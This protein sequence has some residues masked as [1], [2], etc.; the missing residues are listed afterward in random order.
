MKKI[1]ICLKVFFLTAFFLISN[2][3]FCQIRDTNYIDCNGWKQGVWKEV[4]WGRQYI[5]GRFL[6]NNK[7]GEWRVFDDNR[8]AWSEFYSEGWWF[9]QKEQIG[10]S[11]RV[12]KILNQSKDTLIEY[13]Y[14]YRNN[15]QIE[16]QIWYTGLD[17]TNYQLNR[18]VSREY[19]NRLMKVKSITINYRPFSQLKWGD[20]IEIRTENRQELVLTQYYR[21][22][23]RTKV[24]ICSFGEGGKCI[25]GRE[26]KY[27]KLQKGYI[28]Y[29]NKL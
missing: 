20:V 27:K 7:E 28:E 2:Y 3:A 6:N 18:E 22:R 14:E 29:L 19:G 11:V 9:M 8:Y 4:I 17:T 24:L 16:E 13:E 5:I 1:Y 15:G 12:S 26:K 21:I 23:K 25:S 10:D